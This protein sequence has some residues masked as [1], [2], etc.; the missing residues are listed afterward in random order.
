MQIHASFY[1]FSSRHPLYEDHE[2][3]LLMD[4]LPQSGIGSVFIRT[5]EI[6]QKF[7]TAAFLMLESEEI[8][9]LKNWQ[10]EPALQ[11]AVEKIIEYAAANQKDGYLFFLT[12]Y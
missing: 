3:I 8:D 2:S 12:D 9:E 1:E 5:C 7:P 10:E 6:G 4:C 11:K